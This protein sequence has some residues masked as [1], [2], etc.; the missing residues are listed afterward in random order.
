MEVGKGNI[1][2]R[3]LRHRQTHTHRKKRESEKRESQTQRIDPR[4]EQLAE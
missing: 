4:W 3:E 1:N 2:W